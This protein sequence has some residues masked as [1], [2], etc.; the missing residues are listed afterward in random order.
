MSDKKGEFL[1][2]VDG[3]RYGDR[4]GEEWL[5]EVLKAIKYKESRLLSDEPVMVSFRKWL[6]ENSSVNHWLFEL[7]MFAGMYKG[8]FSDFNIRRRLWTRLGVDERAKRVDAVSRAINQLKV[9]LGAED[10]F[11]V[12]NA[13]DLFDCSRYYSDVNVRLKEQ[14][15]ERGYECFYDESV[16]DILGKLDKFVLV[17]S[18]VRR[19]TNKD[20]L[21]ER[22]F[23]RMLG[24]RI[25]NVMLCERMPNKLIASLACDFFGTTEIASDDV[26]SWLKGVGW[27]D[28]TK[29]FYVDLV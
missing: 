15:K 16:V 3:Y 29:E 9:L 7:L 4:Y 28:E 5:G 12:P 27:D 14:C 10:M 18:H 8:F 23:V 2:V 11:D 17:A 13:I 19:T 21:E 6:R 20:R 24:S 1:N 22:E 26:K 25:K